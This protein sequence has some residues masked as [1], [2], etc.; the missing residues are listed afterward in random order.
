MNDTLWGIAAF[1][2][3]MLWT[4]NLKLK[5]EENCHGWFCF[6]SIVMQYAGGIWL[7]FYHPSLIVNLATEWIENGFLRYL[8]GIFM[9]FLL[10]LI[11]GIMA[12]VFL[13]I[14]T[15]VSNKSIHDIAKK[16]YG[17]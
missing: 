15:N 1:V 13:L 3:M 17:S 6:V 12:Y 14:I 11:Y 2:V 8:G 7:L 10:L 4:L 9:A 5:G 16:C